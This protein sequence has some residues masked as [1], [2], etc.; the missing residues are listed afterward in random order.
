MEHALSENP[1]PDRTRGKVRRE[2]IATT[3]SRLEG[4]AGL[5]FQSSF[6]AAIFPAKARSKQTGKAAGK[7]GAQALIDGLCQWLTEEDFLS[8]IAPLLLPYSFS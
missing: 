5:T 4:E 6:P 3:R 7:E 1:G 8:L 2:Q